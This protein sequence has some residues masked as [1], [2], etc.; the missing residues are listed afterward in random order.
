MVAV[1][2]NNDRKEWRTLLVVLSQRWI[3]KDLH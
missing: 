2:Y 3:A 1:V